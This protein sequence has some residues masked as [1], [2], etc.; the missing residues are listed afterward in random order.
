MDAIA[1][2]ASPLPGLAGRPFSPKPAATDSG[3]LR[4]AELISI[5]PEGCA[6]GATSQL[7]LPPRK[8]LTASGL[9]QS[10]APSAPEALNKPA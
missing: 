10:K 2:A 8:A 1:I 6:M 9:A 5:Q 4:S 7:V 3:S